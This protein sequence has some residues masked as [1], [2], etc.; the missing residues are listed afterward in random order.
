M[1][2]KVKKP[3]WP[4]AVYQAPRRCLD[5]CP[6]CNAGI[7]VGM[8]SREGV[9]HGLQEPLSCVEGLLHVCQNHDGKGRAS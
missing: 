5:V 4:D 8:V 7:L 3:A 6:V 1:R 2:A 9:W